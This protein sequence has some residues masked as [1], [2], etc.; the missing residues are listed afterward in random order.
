MATL[1]KTWQPSNF[2]EDA[3]SIRFWK[4]I[5]GNDQPERSGKDSEIFAA[6]A[7]AAELCSTQP[8]R[9]RKA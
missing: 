5:T 3:R 2:F 1:P 6:L 9:T 4:F 8:L 7:M